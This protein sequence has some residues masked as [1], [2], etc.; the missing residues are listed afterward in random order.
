[1]FNPFRKYTIQFVYFLLPK[2]MWNVD[3][4]IVKTVLPYSTD[5]IKCTNGV[6]Y[7]RVR[8]LYISEFSY[9]VSIVFALFRAWQ[10]GVPIVQR[11]KIGLELSV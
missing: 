10:F 3:S 4:P 6:T 8:I 2:R 7:V 1:M 11:N 9:R 5:R